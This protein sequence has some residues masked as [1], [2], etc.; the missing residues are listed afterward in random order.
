MDLS[1]T[2]IKEFAD[3][4]NEPKTNSDSDSY[5]RGT[6]RVQGEKKYVQIDGSDQLTPILET[7]DVQ[8]GDR[9]LV[10]VKNHVATIMGNFTFPPS[11]RKE[12]EAV[13]KAEDAQGSANEASEK[14]QSAIQQAGEANTN[15]SAASALAGEAKEEAAAAQVAADE[16]KQQAQTAKD[17]ADSAEEKAEQ[18]HQ[19]AQESQEATS[20]A[21]AEISKINEDV[22]NVKQD[23]ADSLTEL[24]NL[25]K[26]TEAIK[27]T[28]EVEYAKKTDVSTVEASLKTEISK[29]V[30]ELQT[31][32][33][34][35]YA[36]K[37]EI[38]ELEGKL[39]TQITQN[40][41]SISSQVTKIEK[42]E[43]DTAAAQAAVDEAKRTAAQAK[44]EAAAAQANAT[45][46]KTAAD[47][48]SAAAT[49]AD[50]K[51]QAAQQT[52]DEAT[53]A[54]EEA[55]KNL[56]AARTDLDEA[57][58][59]LTTVTSRVDATEEEIAA[60]QEAVSQA[61]A[62]VTQALEDVAEAQAAADKATQAATQAKQE[63]QTAQGAAQAAQNK[64]DAAEQVANNAQ[65]A[66]D[67][68]QEDVAALTKRV[69]KAETN[70]TQNSE[71]IS[72]N[73]TKVEEIGDKLVN[74]YY[75][76]TQTDAAIKVQ[77]D[78]ITNTV[79]KVET[80][81]KKAITSS[82][83][84]F[85]LSNS[86]TSLSGGSW[87]TTQPTWTQ[88]KYI[89][90][91]TLVTKGDGIQSYQ[92][93]QNGVCI[94]GN[95]GATGATGA[96]GRDGADGQDGSDGAPGKDGVGVK[97]TTITYQASTS[98]TTAPTGTWSTSI[99]SV[100]A[101]SYLWTRTIINYTNNTSSTF[102]SVSKM[103]NNGAAGSP[104]SPGKDGA[105]G[106]DGTGISSITVE[107][108]LSTS[109]TSQ[110]GGSWTTT[111][112]TWS[113]GKYLWTRQKIVYENPTS[114]KYTTPICDSSWE[115][116]NEIEVG[117]RNLAEGTNHGK[118]N[119]V[120]SMQTGDYTAEDYIVNGVNGVKFKR[121]DVAQSGWNIIRYDD[122]KP[123]KYEANTEYTVSFD[124][125]ADSAFR[126]GVSFRQTDG[127]NLMTNQVLSSPTVANQ[128]TKVTATL[129]T[130]ATLP[131][132]IGRQVL[133]LMN[134]PADVGKTYYF[135]NLMIEKGNK[136]SDWS[137][138]P[139]DLMGYTDSQIS[140]AAQTITEQYK[141]LIDQTADQINLM[142]DQLRSVT[143]SQATS[144]TSISNQLQITSEMAQFVKTTT[145]KLQ[146]AVDGKLS[147]TEVQ[148][149]AR[150]DGANLELGAS[151]Q[152]FKCRLSTTELAF[153]QG[154]NKVAWI[155]NNELNILTAIIAK[156]IGCGNF[157]FV[158]E[159]DLGFSLM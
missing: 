33:S 46:A 108:Y 97:S 126:F 147:A 48:A 43:S 99:P 69:T 149:W 109:K 132:E 71:Q 18:A 104:G 58:K 74:D 68:A 62:N 103:G 57:K 94:T 116:V 45:A 7:V 39:Q 25:S 40:A 53:K 9:V 139:E 146:N 23:V 10:T 50:Q 34:Q 148:E 67:K 158:D 1:R 130:L 110:T 100:A 144:I 78:R 6:A 4:V 114:T 21:Q 150:F 106:A 54:V 96:P 22:N 89:W 19:T 92:P 111:L 122:I 66:A 113:P 11:A 156:S 90:R 134:T 119:W 41:E 56:A 120:W 105:D 137:P 143:N 16:A 129:K 133:Y 24:G 88:G 61:Q 17:A 131:E 76:K 52:A 5:V 117:G 49:S 107:F 86:P 152:P 51:A 159:G 157:T 31:T 38:T 75:S 77:A 153:Y 64:A 63:A 140:S 115:A 2:L 145:E 101:G 3:M 82:V 118:S 91:R 28:M 138:A 14:A 135:K 36:A 15:A 72:L 60:A 55:D 32:I 37:T 127:S 8:E 124:C 59:N 65:A 98:G 44:T 112:P 102:Y 20:T 73:A 121:G 123:E 12:Q 35:E 79:S 81:E 85:Y 27:E 125:L 42:I 84:Q 128:W 136:A 70:I 141:T 95:T 29:A 93:S 87:S 154:S 155:S 47:A 80:V 83:E 151:N 30:G 26:E 13:D 142:V